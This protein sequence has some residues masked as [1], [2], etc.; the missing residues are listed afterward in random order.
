MWGRSGSA[1]T[2]RRADADGNNFVAQGDLDHVLAD[3]GK[4]VRP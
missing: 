4:G 1:I 3:W 2:D